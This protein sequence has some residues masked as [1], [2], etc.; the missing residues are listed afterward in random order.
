MPWFSHLQ[1]GDDGTYLLTRSYRLAPVAHLTRQMHRKPKH[2]SS[3]ETDD[4]DF[5]LPAAGSRG[6]GEEGCISAQRVPLI[7]GDSGPQR[8]KMIQAGRYRLAAP[9]TRPEEP[10]PGVGGGPAGRAPAHVRGL[11]VHIFASL[12]A[13]RLSKDYSLGGC[14]VPPHL[15]GS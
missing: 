12:K 7:L 11:Q 14:C 5:W 2:I 10:Q 6:P 4:C 9:R 8:Q 15:P 13:W 3:Y 1:H